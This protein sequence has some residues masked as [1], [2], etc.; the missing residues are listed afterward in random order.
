MAGVS[1]GDRE[2][3][4]I[5]TRETDD[6]LAT[7][8]TRRFVACS[9]GIGLL[10]FALPLIE[11]GA[12]LAPRPLWSVIYLTV[13]VSVVMVGAWLARCIVAD[14][15]EARTAHR[16]GRALLATTLYVVLAVGAT[17]GWPPP[18][19]TSGAPLHSVL[20]RLVEFLL[21]VCAAWGT[22]LV[23]VWRERLARWRRV[24]RGLRRARRA[25]AATS[26]AA[27]KLE[28]AP[29][30]L[31]NAL[32]TVIPRLRGEGSDAVEL[33]DHIRALLTLFAS[34]GA[35]AESTVAE[36]RAQLKGFLEIEQARLAGPLHVT[37]D[38]AP[39][40]ADCLLPDLILQPIVE[41]AVCHGCRPRGE[42]RLVIG[43][44]VDRDETPHALVVHV[45]DDGVGFP[46]ERPQ[47][48]GVGLAN[49][50]DRL[51][52]LYGTSATLQLSAGPARRGTRVM[53]R[54]PAVT[55]SPTV[56]PHADGML[57][58][59]R[60]LTVARTTQRAVVA[61]IA[62]FVLILA[63]T[64]STTPLVG[65]IGWAL[66]T[67]I[68]PLAVGTAG[69]AL[70]TDPLSAVARRAMVLLGFVVGNGLLAGLRHAMLD[71]VVTGGLATG[72]FEVA[73]FVT[74]LVI[75]VAAAMVATARHAQTGSALVAD[76]TRRAQRATATLTA[77]TD[78]RT[79]RIT[80]VTMGIHQLERALG[81][82]DAV[83]RGNPETAAIVAFELAALLR[84]RWTPGDQL[85]L[86][87][88]LLDATTLL[89]DAQQA[90]GD[91][92]PVTVAI[93]PDVQHAAVPAQLIRTLVLLPWFAPPAEARA[94]AALAV[95]AAR[96]RHGLLLRVS[97]GAATA[98]A[99][100]ELARTILAG[101]RAT[102]VPIVTTRGAEVRLA[103][104]LPLRQ[105]DYDTTRMEAAGG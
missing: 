39:D 43:A 30:F 101:S 17:I 54:L 13:H 74:A 77:E 5:T 59:R 7:S 78:R 19:Q 51:A 67:L 71:A 35:I 104:R 46:I 12:P 90:I 57:V 65:S 31:G 79:D 28:L 92:T 15:S 32:A 20:M 68:A 99:V 58:G 18:V 45:E 82:L 41:N 50:M 105:A 2:A 1:C 29:H 84:P 34:R 8:H 21:L 72:G 33:L 48:L 100:Y 73:A 87:E 102:I 86:G 93:T 55:T 75:T 26:L 42:G 36:A 91:A 53:L 62:T 11:S 96:Q 95:R 24:R 81:H 22:Q 80:R 6:R 64:Q 103:L 40:A 94:P 16:V 25:D 88:A 14:D 61:A 4:I 49:A 76:R 69:G 44:F 63:C 98:P 27:L 97:Y 56:R 60:P 89:G 52:L 23:V 83:R 66:A 85:P 3:A 70:L 10:V 38:I 9:G 37:W 47:P